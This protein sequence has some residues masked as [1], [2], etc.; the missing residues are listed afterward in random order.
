MKGTWDEH[1]PPGASQPQAWLQQSV[2]DEQLLPKIVAIVQAKERVRMGAQ[3][4]IAEVGRWPAASRAAGCFNASH[5]GCVATSA[6]HASSGRPTERTPV[7]S[8]SKQ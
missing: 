4:S 5:R 1:G 3:R 6:I 2:C 8:T 7:T